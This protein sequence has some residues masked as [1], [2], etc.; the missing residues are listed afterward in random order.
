MTGPVDVPAERTYFG[1]QLLAFADR[2]ESENV[3][4]SLDGLFARHVLGE[5]TS[6][7]WHVEPQLDE[8]L[9]TN[10]G[11]LESHSALAVL[12]YLVGQRPAWL[13][14][15][16]DVLVNGLERLVGRDPYPADRITPMYSAG[17]VLGLYL[18]AR[19]VRDRVPGFLDWL[20]KSFD[21]RLREPNEL[22]ID[23]MQRH[24][25]AELTGEPAK[26]S[27]LAAM[28]DN[29]LVAA[30]YLLASGTSVTRETPED[31][32]VAKRRAMLAF[33]RADPA[34]LEV[35]HAALWLHFA[36]AVAATSADQLVV[37]VPQVSQV[38]SRFPPA[39]KRWVWDPSHHKDPKRWRVDAEREVQA[40][41][42][43]MLRAV[44]DDVVDEENLPKLGHSAYR[45]DFALPRLGLL[46]E[47][48]YVRTKH[49]FKDVEQE[50]IIDSI[51]YLKDSERY[52]E[53]IVFIYDDSCSTEHH[54]ETRRAL[55]DLPGIT[56]VIIVSRPG[57]IPSAAE[58]A[59]VPPSDPSAP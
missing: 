49:H 28:T 58:R 53:V 50:V 11:R 55:I 33:L 18:A 45:A 8:W 35:R 3:P 21:H 51:G 14:V 52:R 43:V 41:L 48:K 38:L 54:D 31:L 32:H 30:F 16:S 9:K 23:L 27:D 57:A 25:L 13:P 56:D 20:R 6:I 42:W 7:R 44:F 36:E 34:H 39:M 22:W 10:A 59:A 1:G 15:V 46:V 19:A 12:G 29:A 24:V 40:I 4:G 37:S 26:V 5:G 2:V 17:I 47:V